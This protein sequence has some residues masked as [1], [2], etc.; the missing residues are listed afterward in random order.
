MEQVNGASSSGNTKPKNM[1]EGKYRGW[2]FTDYREAEP[3]WNAEK[4]QYLVYGSEICPTTGRHHWQGW[5]YFKSTI[6]WNGRI[7]KDFLGKEHRELQKGSNSEA[8]DYCKKDEKWKEFGK[9]PNNNGGNHV[10]PDEL[11]KMTDEEIIELD[12]RC[13]KAYMNAREILNSK[14]TLDNWG[15]DVTVYWIQGPSGCG[16]TQKAKEIIREYADKYGTEISL[17]KYVN[18][19]WNGARNTKVAVYDDFRDSHMRASEFIQFIDYNRQQMNV[20]GGEKINNYELIII[21]SVQNIND[22][23]Q[24]MSSEPRKQWM[25]RVKIIDLTPEDDVPSGLEGKEQ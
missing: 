18:N 13:H 21:T 24:K 3:K 22:I 6:T 11:K 2:C 12:T 8:A 7:M 1:K 25:R 14:I 20:K 17:V 16:K 15:K 23:Y 10:S 5:V 4:M 19:F 9:M